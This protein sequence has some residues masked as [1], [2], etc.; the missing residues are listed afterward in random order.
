MAKQTLFEKIKQS[1]HLPQLPQ[2]MLQ[3]IRACNNGQTKVS[4][5]TRIISADPALTS[6]LM[7][8]MGSSYINLPK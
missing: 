6:K 5:L 7:Q 1:G 4:E 3:L 8:I 2:V